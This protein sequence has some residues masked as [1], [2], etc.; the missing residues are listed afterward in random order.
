[1]K[2]WHFVK[3][4]GRA[5]AWTIALPWHAIKMN[6]AQ[7]RKAKDVHRENIIYIRDLYKEA[8]SRS[9]QAR[10]DVAQAN[11]VTFDEAMRNR[12]PGAPSTKALTR[13]FIW[14]KRLALATCV[15]FVAISIIA[16]A[17]GNLMGIATILSAVPLFF[18]A[19]LSA[20]LRLWQLRTRRLSRGEKG[21]L[22][23]FINENPGW[24]WQVLDP[25]LTTCRGD[26]K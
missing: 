19:S 15:C 18:M 8:T 6:M 23:D 16:L 3:G 14:Q 25:E 26:K 11:D 4:A 7:L 12:G 10:Q 21:G 17:F 1:M 20:H 22:R 2:P 13:R 24:Y 9:R 5:A